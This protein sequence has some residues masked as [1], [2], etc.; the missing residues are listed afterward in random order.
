MRKIVSVICFSICCMSIL[1]Q[2]DKEVLINELYK[3]T[4]LGLQYYLGKPYPEFGAKA[5]DGSEVS[6]ADLRGKVVMINFWYTAC[7]PCVAELAE[8]N[9]LYEKHKN[10]PGFRYISISIDS[11]KQIQESITT[12]NIPYPVY[13]L[14]KEQCGDLLVRGYPTTVFL[15]HDGVV[16]YIK[17][18]GTT[19]KKDVA[20]QVDYF[21]SVIERLL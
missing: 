4:T 10:N 6:S 13:S 17:L 18:G 19:V 1:A 7:P 21:N 5:M 8:L 2:T 12:Y 9:K 15:D 16:Q 11:D 20:P 3:K 14:S